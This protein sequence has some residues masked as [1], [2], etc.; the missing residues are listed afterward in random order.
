MPKTLAKPRLNS[1]SSNKL[2]QNTKSQVEKITSRLL[3]NLQTF[4]QNLF[5]GNG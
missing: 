3:Q 2:K 1:N 5:S 4:E